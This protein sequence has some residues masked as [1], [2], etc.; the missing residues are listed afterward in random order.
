[1]I[2]ESHDKTNLQEQKDFSFENPLPL[3]MSLDFK[4]SQFLGTQ[5]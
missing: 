5:L 1:M 2:C 3:R 4:F